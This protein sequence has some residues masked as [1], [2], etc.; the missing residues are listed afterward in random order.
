MGKEF[1]KLKVDELRESF[2]FVSQ[3]ADE[4]GGEHDATQTA[5]DAQLHVCHCV[6]GHGN[7]C[8]LEFESLRALRCHQ[9]RSRG[10]THGK[11]SAA[12]MLCIT[13]ECVLCRNVYMS[14]QLTKTHIGNSI[15][16]GLCRG[17]GSWSVGQA[18]VP[19]HIICPYPECERWFDD[20]DSY[21]W[22]ARSH[23]QLQDFEVEL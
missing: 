1:R 11:I 22:H 9:V 21:S 7:M 13:N 19:E 18:T 23:L 5:T 12:R 3:T 2:L 20:L 17:G 16:N 14:T 10:G 4:E 6:D 15:A 8:G